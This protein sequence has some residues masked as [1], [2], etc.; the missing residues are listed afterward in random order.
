[1][2]RSTRF[3]ASFALAAAALAPAIGNTQDTKARS[4]AGA[5]YQ[6]HMNMMKGMKEMP[7]PTGDMDYDFAMMMRQH[8][9]QAIDMAQMELQNGK[10]PQMRAMAQKL[11]DS[12][13]QEIAEFDKWLSEYK[14]MK[15]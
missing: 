8:H 10:N 11:V 1:M 9:K 3:V 13:K 4:Q 14:S 6:M 5:S 15:K 12:Q 2:H 7:K